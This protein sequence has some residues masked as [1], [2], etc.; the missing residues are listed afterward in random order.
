MEINGNILAIDPGQNGGAA[1]FSNG[2]TKTV[3]FNSVLGSDYISIMAM[4]DGERAADACNIVHKTCAALDWI[5][6][7]VGSY[8]LQ[9]FVELVASRPDDNGVWNNA[10]ASFSFGRNYGTILGWLCARHIPTTLILPNSWES[11]YSS[12]RGISDYK[13]RKHALLGEAQKLYPELNPTLATC[14][15]LLLLNYIQK[16]YDHNNT[17][18]A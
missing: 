4:C 16:N 2:T 1:L 10:K 9:A 3:S 6:R 15:A 8:D 14:D 5:I 11:T 12:A 7:E 13:D 18:T 17:T